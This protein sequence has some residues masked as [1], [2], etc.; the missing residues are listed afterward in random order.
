MSE[1]TREEYNQYQQSIIDIGKANNQIGYLYEFYLDNKDNMRFLKTKCY[2]IWNNQVNDL[3]KRKSYADDVV[4]IIYKDSS[5]LYD[6]TYHA[7]RANAANE[8][9]LLEE[10]DEL[11]RQ[12]IMEMLNRRRLE[13]V[14][15]MSTLSSITLETSKTDDRFDTM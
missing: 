14:D 5:G 13:M 11:A 10:N 8:I 7:N 15:R 9:F 2:Y 4:H 12:S 3:F 6:T 1:F